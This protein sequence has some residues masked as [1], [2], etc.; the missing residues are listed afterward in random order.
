MGISKIYNESIQGNYFWER[1]PVD[2]LHLGTFNLFLA[3]HPDTVNLSWNK[4]QRT[5]SKIFSKIVF[6]GEFLKPFQL[7]SFYG[8]NLQF[9]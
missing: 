3:L 5:V 4:L 9:N 6:V 8:L 7:L 2:N 1:W